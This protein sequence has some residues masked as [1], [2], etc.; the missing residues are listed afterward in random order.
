MSNLKIIKG[1]IFTSSAQV[2]VNTVNCVGVMGAGIALEFRLRYPKMYLEYVE[3]CKNDKIRIGNLWLFKSKKKWIL[4]F[5]TKT[6]WKYPSKESYLHE[7]LRYF[8][9][10][11]K[12]LNI[13]SIAFPLLGAQK[14]GLDPKQSLQIMTSY[15]DNLSIPVEIY[16]YDPKALDD[17]YLKFKLEFSKMNDQDLALH[18]GL[19][20]NYL[21]LIKNALSDPSICQLNQLAKIQGIGDKTL[22]KAFAFVI[23]D[24]KNV[25]TGFDY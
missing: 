17:I 10:H 15:L 21:T 19:R 2:L 7:G 3:L 8:I 23:N 11:Y 13:E 12:I 14:G 22:E 9:E 24:K 1:N 25:Q 18:S 5:P 4:N 6:D 20:S 16:E